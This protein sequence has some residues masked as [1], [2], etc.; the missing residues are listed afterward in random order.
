VLQ[1]RPLDIAAPVIALLPALAAG[2]AN[3]GQETATGFAH[4]AGRLTSNDADGF[5]VVVDASDDAS[6]EQNEASAGGDGAGS[7]SCQ[8]TC[9]GCCNGAAC[10]PLW[11]QSNTECGQYGA[12][13]HD[14]TL[15]GQT[16]NVG[17]CQSGSTGTDAGGATGGGGCSTSC[18][19]C[20]DSSGTCQPGTSQSACGDGTPGDLCQ[21]CW[22]LVCDP[23][24]GGC[25]IF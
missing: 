15:G 20:C 21:D 18:A 6:G 3:G 13:C 19:G 17:A 2:C 8:A 22:P 4:D 16:C 12:A 10:V 25:F 5:Q 24:F 9:D 7:S 23:N 1:W 14:C 11:G